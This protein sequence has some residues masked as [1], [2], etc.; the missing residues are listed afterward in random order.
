MTAFSK[1]AQKPCK[2]MTKQVVDEDKYGSPINPSLEILNSMQTSTKFFCFCC[3]DLIGDLHSKKKTTPVLKTV[4][5][6]NKAAQIPSLPNSI[7][8]E[9]SCAILFYCC[10]VVFR[11]KTTLANNCKVNMMTQFY[12]NKAEQYL[13]AMDML[14]QGVATFDMLYDNIEGDN[15]KELV[16]KSWLSGVT[17]TNHYVSGVHFTA[18]SIASVRKDNCAVTGTTREVG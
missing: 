16:L 3:K 17:T 15:G 8:M 6:P 4:S 5:A 10:S 11:S 14:I 2:K 12:G 7:R 9:L 13:G 18:E 1:E